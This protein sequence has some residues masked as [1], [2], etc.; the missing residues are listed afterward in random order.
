MLRLLCTSLFFLASLAPSLSESH[1]VRVAFFKG[2]DHNNRPVELSPGGDF[3]HVAIQIEGEWY[4]ASTTYGVERISNL[5]SLTEDGMQIHSMLESKEPGLT[6]KDIEPYIGL[7]FDYFYEWDCDDKTDCTKY[8]ARLLGVSPTRTDFS[9][10]HWSVSY[11]VEVGGFGVSP[12]ELYSRLKQKKFYNVSPRL[13]LR[14]ELE[15]AKEP[16]EC[17]HI[18]K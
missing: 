18:L 2:F 3:F 14:S 12:D 10:E 16:K 1:S 9:A 4:H 6:K 11:G 13:H 5:L 15:I 7:P 17:R 8:V